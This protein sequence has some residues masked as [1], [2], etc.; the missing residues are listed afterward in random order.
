MNRGT[1]LL[2]LIVFLGGCSAPK[3][4]PTTT[5]ADGILSRTGKPVQPR[6]AD[7]KSSLPPGVA[8][9]QPLTSDDATGIALW[10]NPQL[11]ADLATLGLA[12]SDLIDAGLM[13]NPRL[14]MLI[15]V[16]AKP[17][18]LL[19]NFPIE[20]FIQRPHRIAASQ[21]ALDQLAQSSFKTD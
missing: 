19:L 7:F 13:R 18:E 5:T 9:D 15:P 8:L 12:E 3:V 14:D 4:P 10:N 2:V 17:F 11:R 1:P 16:G 21:Q 6:S 20:A